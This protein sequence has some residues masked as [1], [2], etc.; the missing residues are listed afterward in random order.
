M[1]LIPEGPFEQGSEVLTD[2]HP[3]RT[4]WVSAFYMD[5]YECTNA[6]FAQFVGATGTQS[7]AER[8][9][10]GHTFINGKMKAFVGLDW[11]H[12][13]GTQDHLKGRMLHP[14][15]Q[16][17]HDDATEYCRWAHKRLPTEAEWEKAARGLFVGRPFPWGDE[18]P[19]DR[20]AVERTVNQGTQQVGSYPPNQFGLCDMA[21]NAQEW[22]LD[23]FDPDAYSSPIS[24]DPGLA[25]SAQD[26]G[27][28]SYD[29]VLRG[30]G[31]FGPWSDSQVASRVR[32]AG[33]TYSD[34]TT[35]FR[36]VIPA[37]DVLERIRALPSKSQGS[38]APESFQGPQSLPQVKGRR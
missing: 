17:S 13:R 29:R 15:V 4:V 11:R 8:M 1:V 14:V 22:C 28:Y 19:Q 36:G 5:V 12:P 25:E 31:Y 16:M 20:A 33:G 37:T 26:G 30:G 9:G 35:G 10:R 3:V 7:L 24:R 2:A 32:Q 34:F 18:M 21:G 38:F 27:R 23:W 6:Q